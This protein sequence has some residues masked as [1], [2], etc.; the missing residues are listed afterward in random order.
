[1]PICSCPH[2]NTFLKVKESQLNIA[3]GFV[4]CTDCQGMFKAKDFVAKQQ[5]SSID[6]MAD[7]VSD[8]EAV[9]RLGTY[10]RG[11][12]AFDKQQ[13][14]YL[15]EH[16]ADGSTPAAVPHE[17]PRSSA[18]AVPLPEPPAAA[19]SS[20]SGEGTNW[21]LATLVA[22]TILILQLFYILL[23]R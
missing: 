22:L 4:R 9:R 6:W 19:V 12:N 23:T 7:G 17:R 18:Q 14:D 3:Q 16:P 1:M 10:V 13:I 21:T 8:I 5:I 15:L 20:K 2:C 11:R